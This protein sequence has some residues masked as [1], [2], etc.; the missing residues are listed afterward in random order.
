[1]KLPDGKTCADCAHESRCVKIF[2]AASTDTSCGFFPRRFVDRRNVTP[3]PAV[4][5]ATITGV[6]RI[7]RCCETDYQCP[8]GSRVSVDGHDIP[9]DDAAKVVNCPACGRPHR[10]ESGK[11]AP[12]VAWPSKAV[13]K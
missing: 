9:R 11:P 13:S 1:M 2:G 10:F 5:E 8:C 12:L 7:R 4:R 3:T 6:E